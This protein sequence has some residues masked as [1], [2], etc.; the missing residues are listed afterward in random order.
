MQRRPVERCCDEPCLGCGACAAIVRRAIHGSTGDDDGQTRL[1]LEKVDEP[2]TEG[3]VTA[4]DGELMA[5]LAKEFFFLAG[6]EQETC[7][8]RA[9][10]AQP[11]PGD[12]F[13]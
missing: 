2:A 3:A 11:I 1:I 8:A 4:D 13:V 5:A 12:H 9:K 7:I 10:P 6:I